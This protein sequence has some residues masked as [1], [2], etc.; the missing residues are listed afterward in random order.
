MTTKIKKLDF[1]QRAEDIFEKYKDENMAIFLR[2]LFR[3]YHGT[4][5][6]YR[7]QSLSYFKRM[8]RHFL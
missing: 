7:S 8:R 5:L 6:H 3:K 4:I 1:Y 2:L